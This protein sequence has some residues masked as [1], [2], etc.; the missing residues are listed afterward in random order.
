MRFTKAPLEGVWVVDLEP[1]ADER[2]WFARTW[3]LREF[4]DHGIDFQPVQT[5]LSFNRRKGTLRGLHFQA[6]PHEEAKLVGCV[7]GR[8]F[9]VIVDL[10]PTSPTRGRWASLELGGEEGRL[11]Y[12]PAGFAHGFMTLEDSTLVTYQMSRFFEPSSARGIRFDDPALGIAWPHL[13]PV[14][15]AKDRSYP[16]Y[17]G[18]RT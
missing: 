13:D 5:N 14:V 2:G 10:R 18:P 11:L 8:L 15:S 9:D 6:S 17:D 12:V 7:A 3:C 4:R 1:A 16:P